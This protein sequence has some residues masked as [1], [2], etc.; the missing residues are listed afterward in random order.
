MINLD[1]K[2]GNWTHWFSLFI[3]RNTAVY[4]DAF[5]IEYIPQEVFNKIKHKSITHNI[6]RIQD[7]DSIICIFYCIVFIEFMLAW[8]TLLGY[9]NLFYSN[10]YK[11]KAKQYISI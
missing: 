5:G 8:K 1:N 9:T 6:F 2:K 4:F 7:N 10:D 3:N 11:K